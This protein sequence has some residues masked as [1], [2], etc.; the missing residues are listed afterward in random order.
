MGW[1]I[2]AGNWLGSQL[3]MHWAAGFSC[4]EQIS[5]ERAGQPSGEPAIGDASVWYCG[6]VCWIAIGERTWQPTAMPPGDAFEQYCGVFFGF[7]LASAQGKR[8]GCHLVMH[9]GS[10]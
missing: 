3:V 9:R 7:Q 10:R 8:L 5:L 6:A 2:P 1:S 4:F